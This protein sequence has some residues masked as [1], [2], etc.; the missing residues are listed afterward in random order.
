MYEWRKDRLGDVA[1]EVTVGHVGPMVEEYRGV[2]IP[3]LRSQNVKP[4]RI[5]LDDAKFIDTDF[6]ARLS[7]SVLRPG[8]VVTVRT[9]KPGTTAVIPSEIPVGNCSDLV[10][11]RPGPELDPRWL[12]YYINEIARTFVSANLVGA[13]QQHFN[14]AAAKNILLELPPLAEQ[15]AIA[16]VLGALDDKIAAN[17][18]SVRWVDD[19]LG[20]SFVDLLRKSDA[21]TGSLGD[22]ATVNGEAVIPQ[23]GGTL[24][25]VDISSVGVGLIETPP[26]IS[27][28]DAPGRA[29]RRLRFGDTVWST[30]RPNR[31]SHG[32][33]L[34]EDPLLVAST[35]LAVLTPKHVGFAYLYEATRLP[36]F[37][38]YL[39]GVA[40]GSAYPA[41]RAERFADAPVRLVPE[42]VR[43]QFEVEAQAL[44]LRAAAAGRESAILAETR[45]TLLPL[46]MSGKVRV[47]DAETIIEGVV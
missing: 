14:V 24:R 17:I 38:S 7:K 15:R 20:A 45:D 37:T 23:V 4:H 47:K 16:E 25:Y 2:G 43:E 30:V 31:R 1:Q 40:E 11:T 19:L 32:L 26:E 12:S 41:V 46:L 3:F 5:D 33:N 35:G 36:E 34:S 9:G 29:R 6:H 42:A 13:V 21:E 18:A 8:D 44:R 39:E 28:E 10:I 27:W 22:V